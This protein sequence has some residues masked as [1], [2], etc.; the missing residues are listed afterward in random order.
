MANELVFI[1]DQNE[2]FCKELIRWLHEIGFQ[3]KTFEDTELC[4][5][6][7]DQNPAAVCLDMST[8][9]SSG[10]SGLEFLKRLRLANRDIPIMVMTE[11]GELDA[12]V[13]AMKLG[14]FDYIIKPIQ[15]TRLITNIKRAIEMHTMVHKIDRDR[16][17][18]V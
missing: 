1:V 8:T 18:V 6:T 16:K 3:T 17:S 4:L 12:A 5:N 7:I 14:A 9:G 15:K 11:N 10:L 2:V 13:E